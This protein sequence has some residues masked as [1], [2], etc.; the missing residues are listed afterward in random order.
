MLVHKV[1]LFNVMDE[2]HG[3]QALVLKWEQM[4]DGRRAISHFLLSGGGF[5]FD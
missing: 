3:R 2:L 4:S 1:F 5:S